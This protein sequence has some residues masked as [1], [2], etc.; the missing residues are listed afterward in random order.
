MT[1]WP[2]SFLPCEETR[3]DGALPATAHGLQGRGGA[4]TVTERKYPGS[5][6]YLAEPA[7]APPVAWALSLFPPK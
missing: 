2:I 1:W 4:R 5:A 3:K 7:T 6:L